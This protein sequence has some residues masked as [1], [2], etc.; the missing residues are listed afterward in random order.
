MPRHSE[1]TK[2]AIKDRN[3][4]VALVG[5]YLSLRRVGTKYKALCP[6]A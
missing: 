6:V 1:A 4:I 5:E 3:D 2:S